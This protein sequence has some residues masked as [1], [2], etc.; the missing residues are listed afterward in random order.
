M[1]EFQ[2]FVSRYRAGAVKAVVDRSRAMHVCDRSARL[3]KQYRAAHALWRNLSFLLV[4]GGPVSII[5]VPWYWGLAVFALGVAMAP[6]VQKSAAGFVLEY[7]LKDPDF[8]GEMIE[9]GVL[10]VA[11]ADG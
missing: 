5:W 11:R 9:S 3:P 10:K 4:V 2:E 8:Y 6:A 7:A 1:L